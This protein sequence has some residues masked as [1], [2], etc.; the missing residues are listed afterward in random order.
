MRLKL[1]ASRLG[2]SPRTLQRA[3][4]TFAERP[5]VAAIRRTPGGHRVFT[6]EILEALA[7]LMDWEGRFVARRRTPQA[8]R[9]LRRALAV[10]RAGRGLRGSPYAADPER[11]EATVREAEEHTPLPGARRRTGVFFPEDADQG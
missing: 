10:R 9:A 5:E 6:P 7:R 1:A 8:R 11:W 3:L 4:Q 2:I